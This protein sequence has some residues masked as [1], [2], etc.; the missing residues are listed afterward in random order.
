MMAVADIVDDA[1]RLA[2]YMPIDQLPCQLGGFRKYK[3]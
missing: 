1:Y 3:T 2:I